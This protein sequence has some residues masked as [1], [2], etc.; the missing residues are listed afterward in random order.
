VA[1]GSRGCRFMVVAEEE[2]P[3]LLVQGMFFQFSAMAECGANGGGN[4]T[5]LSPRPLGLAEL[6]FP[7]SSSFLR[8]RFTTSRSIGGAIR[9]IM[10][11]AMLRPVCASRFRRESISVHGLASSIRLVL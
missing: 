1:R 3:R 2:V 11:A 8:F 4:S 6:P 9:L 10:R 5:T 7:A